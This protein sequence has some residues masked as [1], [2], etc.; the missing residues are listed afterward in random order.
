MGKILV[1][2][3]KI[4]KLFFSLVFWHLDIPSDALQMYLEGGNMYIFSEGRPLT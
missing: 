3:G 2:A 4:L 1:V